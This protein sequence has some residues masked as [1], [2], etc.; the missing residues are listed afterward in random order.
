MKK[1]IKTKFSN[2]IEIP[3]IEDEGFLCFAEEH[4]Q[5]PF[6]IKRIYYIYDVINN[7]SRGFHAHKKTK[8]VLFCIRGS[9][10]I[11]LDNGQMREEILINKPNQGVFLDKMMWHEMHDFTKDTVLLVTA[12]EKFNESDYIRNYSLFLHLAKDRLARRF[13]RIDSLLPKL[14]FARK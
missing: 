13:F 14:N 7:A 3:Q 11:I 4:S 2:I 1:V 5:I 6:Q 12:S 8:Q 10:K 9:I